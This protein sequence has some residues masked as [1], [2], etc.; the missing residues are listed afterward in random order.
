ME[1]HRFAAASRDIMSQTM[2]DR[3]LLRKPTMKDLALAILLLI[4]VASLAPAAGASAG[5]AAPTAGGGLQ[6]PRSPWSPRLLKAA[7]TD[8]VKG[9]PPGLS[10]AAVNDSEHL[11]Y[12]A[13]YNWGLGTGS[14]YVLDTRSMKVVT[15]ITE[16]NLNVTLLPDEEHG[17]LWA[18]S[19][20]AFANGNNSTAYLYAGRSWKVLKTVQFPGIGFNGAAWN[21]RTGKFYLTNYGPG[22]IEVYDRNLN[23]LTTIDDDNGNFV[24]VNERTNRVYVSNY[25]DATVTVIDG[26]S[27]TI[28]GDP[29]P[30]GTPALPDGCYSNDSTCTNRDTYSASDGIAVDPVSNRVFVA[31]VNDG[32]FAIVDGATNTLS[33][34]VKLSEGVFAPASLPGLNTALA[35]NWDRSTLQLV[36]ETSG[37]LLQTV[38]IGTPDSP[39]CLRIQ[40]DGGDCAFWGNGA[41][42]LAV[43]R[44]N[45]AIYVVA[46]GD[47]STNSDAT[48]PYVDSQV[49]VLTP[50]VASGG[51]WP[52][53]WR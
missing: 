50:I 52:F 21:H 34:I 38:Q 32:T 44:D 16:P 29:I 30:V 7:V 1:S 37:T 6:S 22:E 40:W 8:V 27:D 28:I 48:D 25:Y 4:G 2:S 18:F 19:N 45:G 20:N 23:H 17:T 13:G 39:N 14:L 3:R 42:A 15:S 47:G 51:G 24:A 26:N 36:N 10:V 5:P 33:K 35:V 53:V 49:W 9:L 43:S 46:A 11:L 41:T 31:N 12:L